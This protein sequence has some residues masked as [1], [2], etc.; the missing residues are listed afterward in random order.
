MIKKGETSDFFTSGG[1]VISKEV[2]TIPRR[3]VTRHHGPHTTPAVVTNYLLG[4]P[5]TA[6]LLHPR[7]S[8]DIL[9]YFHWGQIDPDT[10]FDRTETLH[11]SLRPKLKIGVRQD[12]YLCRVILSPKVVTDVQS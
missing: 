4:S 7:N 10:W 6:G 3:G 1:P 11:Q 12:R 8:T 2:E 5:R 9:H